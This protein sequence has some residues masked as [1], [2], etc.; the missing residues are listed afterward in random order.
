MIAIKQN[1]RQ[2]VFPTKHFAYNTMAKMLTHHQTLTSDHWGV[3]V[4][5][6]KFQ[7]QI[8]RTF[9]DVGWWKLS[10]Q[11]LPICWIFYASPHHM[12]CDVI[13]VCHNGHEFYDLSGSFI[14]INWKRFS[15][16]STFWARLDRYSCVQ[17]NI[18]R[19]QEYRTNFGYFA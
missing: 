16:I 6:V 2:D 4:S 3:T 14:F 15:R 13:A 9:W 18:T 12:A 5:C 11:V 17:H 7:R 1:V 8:C 19:H 10:L